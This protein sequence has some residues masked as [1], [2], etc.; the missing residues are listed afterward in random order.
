MKKEKEVRK[1]GRAARRTKRINAPIVHNPALIPNVPVY[2]V[3]NAEGVEQIHELAMRIV[4]DIGVD[5]RENAPLRKEGKSPHM[6]S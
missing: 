5:F 1:G 6:E 3:A 4:E 2:E